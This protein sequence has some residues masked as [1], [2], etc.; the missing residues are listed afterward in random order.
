MSCPLAFAPAH[1]HQHTHTHIHTHVY[2]QMLK[3][4]A[5]SLVSSIF[6]MCL[7]DRVRAR[8]CGVSARRV[9]VR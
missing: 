4:P 1:H 5:S 3:N 9:C 7:P 6:F 2:V 8:M